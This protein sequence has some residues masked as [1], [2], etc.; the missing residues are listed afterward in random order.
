MKELLTK[1]LNRL[2]YRYINPDKLQANSLLHVVSINETSK[3]LAETL[4]ITEE[5]WDYLVDICKKKATA[6]ENIST[7]FELCSKECKH[8]NELVMIGFLVGRNTA[9][10][11][12]LS[13]LLGAIL[14]RPGK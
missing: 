3:N 2:R 12:S 6:H 14:S 13:G 11:T 7:V 4:G 9:P 1:I 10:N 8:A 5:R